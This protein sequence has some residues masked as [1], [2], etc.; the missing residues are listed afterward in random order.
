MSAEA[1]K[2]LEQ[3]VCLRG[4]R[5]GCW[6]NFCMDGHAPPLAGDSLESFFLLYIGWRFFCG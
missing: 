1:E 2:G 5:W 3:K 6:P 4:G